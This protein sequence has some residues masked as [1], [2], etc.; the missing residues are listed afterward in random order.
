MNDRGYACVADL[1][2]TQ[3]QTVIAATPVLTSETGAAVRPV[4]GTGVVAQPVS[5]TGIV[6]K[7]ASVMNPAR[8]R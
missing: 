4:A 7:P 8:L 2:A 3:I 5:S 1:L 6:A